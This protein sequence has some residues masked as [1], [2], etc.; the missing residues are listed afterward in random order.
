[1]TLAKGLPGTQIGPYVSINYSEYEHGF[2]FPFGVNFGL[3]SNWDLLA[4]HD[5]RRS[6]LLLTH[7]TRSMNTTL[8][9]I[10]LK[11]PRWGLSIGVGF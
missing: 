5:G 2:N 3:H 10:N 9:L 1:M 6:H 7:K 8:M 4:M 11:Q